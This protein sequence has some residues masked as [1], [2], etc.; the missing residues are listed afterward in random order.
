VVLVDVV[1]V[2]GVVRVGVVTV[3]VVEVEVDWHEACTLFTGPVPEGTIWEG[4]VPG[5]A[6]TVNVSV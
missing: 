6:L 5:A 4:G 1:V 3:G 2:D